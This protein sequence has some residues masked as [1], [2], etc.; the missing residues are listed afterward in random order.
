MQVFRSLGEVP[1]SFGPSVVSIGN[2]D[3]VHRGHQSILQHVIRN[4]SAR[5]LR[6]IAVTF[7]PHPLRILRPETSPRLITPL[8]ARLELLQSTGIDA[9][10]ILPFTAALSRMRAEEFAVTILHDALHAVQ[11]HEG[12]NFRFG[13]RA[14]GGIPELA[15]LGR[16]FGFE[17]VIHEACRL[18]GLTVSS[19]KI[20]ELISKGELRV[21]RALLGHCFFIH[22]TPAHGRGIGSRLT[23]PTINL[24]PYAELLP[25]DG[26]YV[27]ELRI[28]GEWFDAVTNIGNRPTF[29][30]NS[31][32]IESYLLNF[33]PVELTERTP[34]EL[35]FHQR[36]REERRFPS[37]DALKEQILR[38]AARASRYLRLRR[39]LV[40]DPAPKPTA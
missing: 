29:G 33:R 11:V 19:S 1:D 8:E 37:P 4:A 35:V 34:L 16:A 21:A 6:S 38:D 12:P 32:A 31:F 10:L 24:A 20:R 25:P 18:R 28:S 22:S 27:A 7:D 15:A 23:V 17:V 5:R 13:Y 36:I 3:G 30:E 2:F 40:K 9:V 26:V 14:E 39:A